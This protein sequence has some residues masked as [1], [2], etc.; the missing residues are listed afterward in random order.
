MSVN[1]NK[2]NDMINAKRKQEYKRIIKVVIVGDPGTGKSSILLRFSDNTF[3]NSYISTIGVDFKVRTLVINDQLYKIQ[4]WDTAGQ[5]RFKS[6]ITAYYRGAHAVVYVYDVTDRGSF[7]N[8]DKW[9]KDVQKKTFC[10][11]TNSSDLS[12]LIVGNKIDSDE[13]SVTHTEA[14]KY[15]KDRDIDY[16]EVSAR[17]GSCIESSFIKLIHMILE[18]N[19]TDPTAFKKSISIDENN[20]VKKTNECCQ[21]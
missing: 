9:I 1:N 16:V 20:N 13:R 4:I 2:G 8:L 10:T 19:P 14:E 17:T 11:E 21:N 5:E 12:E 6:I 7:N 3:T 15:A 18:K